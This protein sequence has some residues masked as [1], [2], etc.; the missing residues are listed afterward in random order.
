LRHWIG[1][2]V[3]VSVLAGCGGAE[4]KSAPTPPAVTLEAAEPAPETF[5]LGTQITTTGAVPREASG[6]TFLRGR[7]I[8]LS[9]DVTG[10]ST[11]QRIA[12]VWED[13]NGRVLRRQQRE[14]RPGSR[15]APFS[16]GPTHSWRPG[17][18]RAVV[19]IDGRRAAE[20]HFDVM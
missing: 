7:E 15:Y 20:K 18:H 2:V 9:V 3:V 12:V 16:S 4:E 19:V 11:Q 5:A 14:V 8:Y 1:V 17:E 13:A 10:A 6:D